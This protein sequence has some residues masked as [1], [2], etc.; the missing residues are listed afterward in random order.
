MT[1]RTRSGSTYRCMSNT[2][3]GL[4]FECH[5]AVDAKVCRAFNEQVAGN[6]EGEGA[7]RHI[8]RN[9]PHLSGCF[10]HIAGRGFGGTG[11]R[12]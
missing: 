4:R 6:P 5:G 3:R 8:Q 10:F 9:I 2:Q 1:P 12:K 7:P 11:E